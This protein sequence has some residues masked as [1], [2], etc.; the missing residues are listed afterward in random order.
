MSICAANVEGIA[1]TLS[2][3][4]GIRQAQGRSKD[5][6]RLYREALHVYQR[7]DNLNLVAA[8]LDSIGNSTSALSNTRKPFAHSVRPPK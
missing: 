7:L 5:A 8:A 4:A 3:L 2:Y 1:P 6:L